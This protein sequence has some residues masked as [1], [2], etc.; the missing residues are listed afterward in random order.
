MLLSL[1]TVPMRILCLRWGC[2]ASAWEN[3]RQEKDMKK[4][5]NNNINN[6]LSNYLRRQTFFTTACERRVKEVKEG[7]VGKRI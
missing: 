4:E 2:T 7:R 5:K 1:S 6:L 3:H